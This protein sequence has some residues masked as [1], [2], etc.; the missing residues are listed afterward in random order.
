A[1]DVSSF[2]M[3]NETTKQVAFT[4][5]SP[6]DSGRSIAV[7][8]PLSGS[9][10]SVTKELISFLDSTSDAA[11]VINETAG[12]QLFSNHQQIKSDDSSPAADTK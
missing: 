12:R 3:L 11:T 2:Q 4:Q 10:A 8:A 5:E 1:Y 9:G 7:F 6:W